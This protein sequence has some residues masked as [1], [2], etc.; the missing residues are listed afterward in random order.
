MS[1]LWPSAVT[2]P[3]T[4]NAPASSRASAAASATCGPVLPSSGLLPQP[5]SSR[6]AARAVVIGPARTVVPP[7]GGI[8]GTP[9]SG[10]PQILRPARQLPGIADDVGVSSRGT[11]RRTGMASAP[12]GVRAQLLLRGVLAALGARRRT[13][14][15]GERGRCPPPRTPGS[16]PARA[17]S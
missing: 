9:T 4:W 13:D 5:V 17:V 10:A 12:V 11:A 16:H 14:R 3:D 15:A 6:A 2:V 8:P 1:P 7:D